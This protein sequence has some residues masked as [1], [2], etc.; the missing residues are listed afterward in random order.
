MRGTIHHDGPANV[1]VANEIGQ[2]ELADVNILLQEIMPGMFALHLP[3][4][5]TPDDATTV[6]ISYDGQLRTGIVEYQRGGRLTF[7]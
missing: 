4:D 7:R 1:T 6:T 5:R 2:T 3:P